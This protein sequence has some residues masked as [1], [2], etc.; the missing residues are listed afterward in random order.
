M[1]IPEFEGPITIAFFVL[2]LII[3]VAGVFGFGDFVLS[4]Q[5]SALIGGIVAVLTALLGVF[6]TTRVYMRTR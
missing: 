1:N 2:S 3:A 4:E 6:K 5:A